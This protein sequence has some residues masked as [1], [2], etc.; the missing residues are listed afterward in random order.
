MPSQQAWAR[1]QQAS[2]QKRWEE[3]AAGYAG[4]VQ[5]EPGFVPGWLEWS[6][7]LEQLD[8][9]QDALRTALS[10]ARASRD[11]HPLVAIAVVRRLRRF[12]LIPE[13]AHYVEATDLPMRL[14]AER[15]VDLAGFFSSAGLHDASIGWARHATRLKPDLFDAHNMLGLALMFAGR[16]AEATAAFERA[17][18]LSPGSAQVYSVLSRIARIDA[19][20]NH[21]NILR[22]MLAAPSLDRESESH[23][24]Y[25]L[26]N[27]LH[28]LGDYTAAW[29]ALARG[30]QAKRATLEY[31][32]ART[33]RTFEAIK[34][35]FDDP[36]APQTGDGLPD[37]VP[38]F[39]VGMHRSGTTLL[40][41]MLAGSPIVTDAGETYAFPATLRFAANHFCNATIDETIAARLRAI[42][43]RF[44]ASRFLETMAWRGR[45]N[46]FVTE[47]LNPNFQVAGSILT[48]LPR[49]RL[50]HMARDPVDTC[51]SNLR[52]MFTTEAPYSYD[53]VELADYYRAYRDLMAFWDDRFPGA[54]TTID[55][56][57][58]VADPRTTAQSVATRCG[59]PF[60]EAMLEVDRQGGAVSTASVDVVRKGFLPNRGG[61]WEP[62]R[63]QL[64]PLI[65]RLALP[66]AAVSS[67]AVT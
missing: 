32:H 13:M 24:A 59:F 43:Y 9:Y 16:M 4:I 60:V 15:L 39:I 66:G 34:R 57:A 18:S 17:L 10:A 45:G 64:A 52:T 33:L 19:A 67:H 62:Y 5:Q 26:H 14:P 22:R 50:L 63:R 51:F 12:E 41:R 3:A 61:A 31:D 65:D 20:S 53:M 37:I 27:E 21:V 54:I 1:A 49:A 25:A 28:A 11:P 30:M 29:D 58:M 8:R 6:L 23:L 38:I 48:A 42:D 47:K 55:Y 2:V 36:R 35:A 40:E 7:A 56:D 46:R 44:V